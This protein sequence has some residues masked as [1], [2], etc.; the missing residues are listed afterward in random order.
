MKNSLF[1]EYLKGEEQIFRFF[2]WHLDAW[3]EVIEARLRHLV[4]QWSEE[5]ILELIEYNQK[6]GATPRVLEDI[7]CLSSKETLVIATGQQPALLGGPLYNLYKALTAIKLAKHLSEQFKLKIIPVFWL[8]SDDHDFDEVKHLFW[9]NSEGG[10][11]EYNYQ[12]TDYISARPLFKIPVETEQIQKLFQRLSATTRDTE[13]KEL[14]LSSLFQLVSSSASFEEQFV[15]ILSWLLKEEGLI[16]VPPYLSVVRERAVPLISREIKAP[17]V[18]TNFIIQTAGK[19]EQL[20]YKP[21][22][23][24]QPAQVNFFLLDEQWRR[25]RIEYQNNRFNLK[26]AGENEVVN[27][28]TSEEILSL[29][30][31]QPERISFNVV[32][33]PLVQDYIFNTIA[34]V[35]GPGEINYFAQYLEVYKYFGVFMPLIFPRAQ[36]LLIEP[37]INRLL[38]KYNLEAEGLFDLSAEQLRDKLAEKMTVSP[39]TEKIERTHTEIQSLLLKLEQELLQLNSIAV[40]GSLA[41]LKGHIATGFNHLKQRYKTAW[42]QQN[43]QIQEHQDKILSAL[44]PRGEPQER[45][46]TP[47][48]PYMQ[49]FGPQ[50]INQVNSVI[51]PFKPRQVIYLGNN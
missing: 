12:P 24:R 43:N 44:L 32:T 11:E 20:G 3:K 37:R 48:F 2:S 6:I 36:L 17:G 27:S 4:P 10:I 49:N 23:W 21:Q 33:R 9:L 30:T 29:I 16:F 7:R 14:L 40:T 13:F 5:E 1:P 8:A 28:F 22:L 47:F 35:A 45:I 41:K 15:R 51:N 31:Q 42:L 25:N 46:F 38:T 26:I 19:L 39:L 34:Y 50:F 18:S